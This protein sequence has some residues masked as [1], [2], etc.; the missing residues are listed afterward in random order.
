MEMV[1]VH[2][3]TDFQQ[4]TGIPTGPGHHATARQRRDFVASI[5]RHQLP[6]GNKIPT[7][8]GNTN[9]DDMQHS[10]YTQWT[11]TDDASIGASVDEIS[12]IFHIPRHNAMQRL[13]WDQ[14]E[15]ISPVFCFR[16]QK[17]WL[18]QLCQL[19]ADLAPRGN[20]GASLCNDSCGLHV[21]FALETHQPHIPWD[22]NAPPAFPLQVLQNLIILWAFWEKNIESCHPFY[23]H[24]KYCEYAQSLL[25]SVRGTEGFNGW[26]GWAEYVYSL[27][28]SEEIRNF[29]GVIIAKFVKVHISPAGKRK[30]E[31]VE[32]REHR[33][34][35]N[36]TEIR[37]WVVFIERVIQYAW[38]TARARF[39]FF[40]PGSQNWDIHNTEDIWSVIEM[41]QDGRDFLR[42]KIH[43]YAQLNPNHFYPSSN[44]SGTDPAGSQTSM[45]RNSDDEMDLDETDD[46]DMDP[47]YTKQYPAVDGIQ[48]QVVG[49][50][51]SVGEDDAAILGGCCGAGSHGEVWGSRIGAV[52][53]GRAEVVFV[54]LKESFKQIN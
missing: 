22:P 6:L 28:S 29:L 8:L 41:P 3:L 10:D 26:T 12:R 1:Y 9:I 25:F 16:S 13:H 27:Q 33:G 49:E 36:A 11:V 5:L 21:H 53:L 7:L 19:E 31:T 52:I 17:T 47:N 37:W 40:V 42:G 24:P 38:R 50:R 51:D 32:F 35:T 48:P 43:E 20:L 15:L 54:G 34:T 14:I 45:N 23:R 18:L 30:R 44:S 4:L 2:E 39:R 46:E